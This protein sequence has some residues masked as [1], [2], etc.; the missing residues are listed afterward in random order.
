M[1]IRSAVLRPRVAVDLN[2]AVDFYSLFQ[3]LFWF[4]FWLRHGASYSYQVK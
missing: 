4:D 1:T 2:N 3:A